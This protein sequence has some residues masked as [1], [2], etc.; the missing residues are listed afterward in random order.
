MPIFQVDLDSA[1]DD[2]DLLQQQVL[3]E[4]HGLDSSNQ[5]TVLPTSIPI[6][7]T[8]SRS[9]RISEESIRT[10][11]CE[12]LVPD[13]PQSTHL[14]SPAVQDRSPPIATSNRAELIERLKRGESPNWIPNRHVSARLPLG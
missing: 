13:S 2:E 12:G 11:L 7:L 5:L 6:S 3:R 1:P 14:I 8:P 9:R 4:H 10:E